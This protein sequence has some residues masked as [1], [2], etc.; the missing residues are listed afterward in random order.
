MIRIRN[1]KVLK[2]RLVMLSPTLLETL[3][4]Y[5]KADRP[6][7]WLFPG[8][9]ADRPITVRAVQEM[10][11]RVKKKAGIVKPA[12]CHTLRHSFATHLME[13]GTNLRYIQE[14]LGHRT[15]T[16]TAIYTKVSRLYAA[17]IMSPL[18]RLRLTQ[19][20]PFG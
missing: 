8:R 13:S 17:Q 3:R 6:K 5:W 7:H 9:I 4:L 12:T 19:E 14:L 2:E 11:A 16:T 15:P 10:F 18:D 1:G 20:A